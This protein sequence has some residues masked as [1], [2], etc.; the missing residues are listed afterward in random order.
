VGEIADAMRRAEEARSA[1]PGRPG[2]A[3][4]LEI[5]EAPRQAPGRLE[6]EAREG[7]DPRTPPS[8]QAEPSL[9]SRPTPVHTPGASPALVVQEL[10][11]NSPAIVS[12]GTP[13]VEACRRLA[14]RLREEMERHE[15]RTVALVSAV[16]G[17]GKTTGVCNLG[18]ALASLSQSRSVALV[19]LDLRKP[20]L[21]GALGLQPRVGFEKV[22]LGAASLDEA[23]IAVQRPPLDLYPVGSPRLAAHELLVTR[24]FA[25]TL[26][27]LERRYEVVLIDTPPVLVVPD[28]ALLLHHVGACVTVARSGVTRTRAFANL[29][30]ALPRGKILGTVF[31]G[32][33][34]SAYAAYPYDDEAERESRPQAREDSPEASRQG[35]RG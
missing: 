19:D 28:V 33:H 7:E 1:E 15:I 10:E 21:A 23:L 6:E 29:M 2:E 18:L 24:R 13:A 9:A 25:D 30:D 27:E 14:I 11:P 26:A 32:G 4:R 22:L 35:G 3:G 17:E 31:N 16:Q 20:S 8:Q 5:A 12:R 34:L